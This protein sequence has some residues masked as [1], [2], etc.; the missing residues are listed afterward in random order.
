MF[1]RFRKKFVWMGFITFSGLMVSC[2]W[3][4]RNDKNIINENTGKVILPEVMIDKLPREIRE[5]SGL[6]LFDGLIWTV[7]DSGGEN[8]LYGIN[9]E[10]GSVVRRVRINHAK[11]RDWETL[12]ANRDYIFIG[13]VG[14]NLGNRK[15]LKIYRVPKKELAGKSTSANAEVISFSWPDQTFFAP[16]IWQTPYDC[17]A[18]ICLDDS[19]MLFTKDWANENTKA[20]MLLAQPGN[21]KAVLIDSL[22]TGVLITG[23]DLSRDGKILILSAY[24]DF[25]PYLWVFTGFSG[26]YFFRG[27]KVRFSYPS[28]HDAQTEGIV[29]KGADSVLISAEESKK[30]DARIYLLRTSQLSMSE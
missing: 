26:H 2:A 7:N 6:F 19:L 18:M 24:H 21:R 30:L 13:D 23:A 11:N 28:F 4:Q 22:E 15:D 25:D 16:S 10:T 20:Y 8:L 14:N 12:S 29:F 5:T 3:S 1:V 17:E 9:Q 27:E